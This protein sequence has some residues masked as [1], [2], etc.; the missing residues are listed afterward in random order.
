[1]DFF[2]DSFITMAT[3]TVNSWTG[4]THG[5]AA[6]SST[7]QQLPIGSDVAFA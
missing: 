3:G 1:M 6:N 7:E 5:Y 4:H 2:D